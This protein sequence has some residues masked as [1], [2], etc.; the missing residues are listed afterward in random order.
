MTP[1][2]IV[3]IDIILDPSKPGRNGLS[4]LVWDMASNLRILG[5]DVHVIGPYT[6]DD[7]PDR[8]VTV[9]QF[10]VPS[11]G[12][13]N[14]I[15]HF[16]M[17][18]RAYTIA[19][20]INDIDIIHTPEYFSGAIISTLNN[21]IP[22]VF[23]EPGN[24]FERISRPQGNPYDWSTTQIYKI[25]AKIISK[26]C[27][28]L[29]ATSETMV[30]WWNWTGIPLNKITLVPLGIQTSIFKKI[31]N[32]RHDLGYFHNDP[33]VVYSSRFSPENGPEIVLR[34]FKIVIDSLPNAQLW[35]IGDWKFI[36]F[37]KS[38]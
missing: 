24:I 33:V 10:N 28:Q 1:L 38:S 37:L 18:L 30:K 20:Q 12:Y 7:Y 16:R 5:N 8:N 9:H 25:C 29:F 19:S 26:K 27:A 36:K 34:A 14:I 4:D 2:R 6:S 21:N 31:P 22:L 17:V 13:Q 3:F 35:M 15:G 11:P 23:T 32:A